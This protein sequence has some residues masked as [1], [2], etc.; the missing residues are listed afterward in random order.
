MIKVLFICHGNICRSAM[1]EFICKKYRS[2]FYCES[3]AVSYEEEGNDMY[4][5]AKR[6]LDRHGVP[7]TRHY[8]KRI[9]QKD[10]DDF[11]VIYVM[12]SSNMRY[13]NRIVDDHD[14]K[15]KMLCDYEI[16]DPWYTGN[17]EKVYE[18]IYEGIIN[19]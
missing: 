14:H 5:P 11:D 7:Y 16:E 19:I 3:R 2:E 15:I 17:F 10:Y 18:E 1:A 12:D 13:I 9:T 6:C 4:P 8:A